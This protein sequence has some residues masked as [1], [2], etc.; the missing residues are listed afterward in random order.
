MKNIPRSRLILTAVSVVVLLFFL[1]RQYYTKDHSES[2]ISEKGV[3]TNVS[4]QRASE[5]SQREKVWLTLKSTTGLVVECG[6]V[7]PR[8]SGKPLPAIIL[9][10]GK[11]TGK[12][13]IDYVP[14]LGDVIVVAVDY[15]YEP[16]ESYTI[17]E[18]IGD[19]PAIRS[20]LMAMVPSVMLLTDYLAQ[21][22]DVDSTRMVVLGY[23][24]GAPFV[25]CIL[26][27]DRRPAVAAMVFGGGEMYSLIEHNVRRYEGSVASKFVGLLG[28]FLL[29][30]LEPLRYAEKISPV[31][32][33]MINGTDDEMIPR[34][35]VELVYKQ[36]LEPK[37]LI[38]LRSSHV[39]PDNV[40][41]T[42]QI[43]ATLDQ[44]LR[45]LG[46]LRE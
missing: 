23:S 26:A 8:S 31:P 41:L 29:W 7:L 9:L 35:N 30:P 28:G 25:P 45:R 22:P 46:I 10:G 17:T 27:T 15:P 34:K 43:V 13:A 1:L 18:F 44:E 42:N 20:A 5:D 21:R 12:Y 39:R 11:A 33:I 4:I 19:V 3:L 40:D 2:F 37:K 24:F 16:R 32:L 14:E 6:I 38:W 36:A